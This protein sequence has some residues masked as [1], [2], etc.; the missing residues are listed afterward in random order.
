[1]S[2]WDT[3]KPTKT[4]T[5][6]PPKVSSNRN[7]GPHHGHKQ[8]D[9]RRSLSSRQGRNV[10]QGNWRRGSNHRKTPG[11]EEESFANSLK[12]QLE[13]YRTGNK[14]YQP[15]RVRMALDQITTSHGT[16]TSGDTIVLL[17]E[18]LEIQDT[19]IQQ[20]AAG[21]LEHRLKAL[22]P[23]IKIT[24]LIELQQNGALVSRIFM[25]NSCIPSPPAQW[26]ILRN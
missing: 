10:S 18:I 21:S 15:E 9:E 14:S 20:A 13:F 17:V 24:E 5:R 11:H 19:S 26:M 25:N 6:G 16:E 8:Q 2:R 22:L 3:L 23:Q 7:A 1:M 4:Q 12:Q